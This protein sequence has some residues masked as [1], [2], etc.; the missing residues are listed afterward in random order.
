MVLTI[1]G[2]ICGA[3]HWAEIEEFARSNEDWFRRFLELPHGVASHDTFGRVFAALDPDEFELGFVRFVECLAGS[4]EEKHLAIDGKSLRRSS[5]WT[6]AWRP[7]S[8][9]STTVTRPPGR[10]TGGW[11]GE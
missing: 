7:V 11:S 10:A 1:C 9:A 8:A 5:I 3:E 2:V 4:S 6:S